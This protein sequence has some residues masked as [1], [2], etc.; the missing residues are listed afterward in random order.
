MEVSMTAS[1]Q[2]I[3]QVIFDAAP[4]ETAPATQE[5]SW[6]TRI[7]NVITQIKEYAVSAAQ[8]AYEMV[9]PLINKISDMFGKNKEVALPA[10]AFGA[11]VVTLLWAFNRYCCGDKKPATV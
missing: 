1:L 6:G 2:A 10:M 3:G 4:A 8:K 7:V 5:A 11:A 9:L